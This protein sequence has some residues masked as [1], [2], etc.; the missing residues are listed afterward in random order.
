MI[1]IA[2]EHKRVAYIT[3]TGKNFIHVVFPFKQRYYDNFCFQR[4][5]EVPGRKIIYH[6]FR[7]LKKEDINDELRKFMLIAYKA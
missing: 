4:I 1:S 3:Q 6:H 7:M 5:Q 2:N